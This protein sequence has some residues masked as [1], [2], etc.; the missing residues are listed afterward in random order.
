MKNKTNFGSPNLIIDDNT[1]DEIKK[2]INSGWVSIG[3]HTET[4]ENIFKERFKVKHAIACSNATTGLIIAVK[5]AGW[6]NKRIAVPSFTWPST[7]YSIESNSGNTP[8]FCDIDEETWLMNPPEEDYDAILAVD[9]FGNQCDLSV[10]SNI[11]IIYDA[12]HGFGLKGLGQRG[13]A[14]VVSFSF[15]KLVTAMEGGMILSN[16]D[17]FAKTATELRRLSGRM[18]EIN[19]LLAKKS[20]EYYDN[21]YKSEKYNKIEKYLKGF[22]FPFKTQKIPTDTNY[23]VFSILLEDQ[24][25][26]NS[27][28]KELEKNDIETKIYYDPIVSGLKNTDYVYSRII[29]LP[30]NKDIDEITQNSI[31]EIMNKVSES[32]DTPGKKYMKSTEFI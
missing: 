6:K 8:V 11:P 28:M 16:D 2:I 4:L 14:E 29:S 18:L 20:I 7:L 15:T 25:T 13:L 5:A 9:T 1:F 3:N 32:C 21:T 31:I 30:I 26:R 12:A 10:D 22:E 27:M 19:A 23:S 24:N 17:Q